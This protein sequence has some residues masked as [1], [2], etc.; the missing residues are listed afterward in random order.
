MVTP[1]QMSYAHLS[2]RISC[3][4]GKRMFE[5][6]F[7]R[8]ESELSWITWVDH[9]P[10]IGDTV[11]DSQEEI[12]NTEEKAKDRSRGKVYIAQYRGI[13]ALPNLDKAKNGSN[14]RAALPSLTIDSRLLQKSEIQF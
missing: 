3:E 5:N 1:Y 4:L 6:R 12:W 7:K 11:R 14:K 2:H 8:L 10:M 13:Y 9:K